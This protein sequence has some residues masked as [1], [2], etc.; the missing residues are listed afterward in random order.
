MGSQSRGT[1]DESFKN[2][3]R[4]ALENFDTVVQLFVFWGGAKKIN[5]C[6]MA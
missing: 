5:S 6:V 1:N 4:I 2:D 3:D